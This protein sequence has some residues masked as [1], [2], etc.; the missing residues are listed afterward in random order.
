ME[1]LRALR[2]DR[3]G[4]TIVEFALVLPLFA[5]LLF[6]VIEAGRVL[7]L[8]NALHYAVEQAAR[9]V[10]IN[11]ALCGDVNSTI[12]YA[13]RISGADLSLATFTVDRTKTGECVGGY[14]VKGD[15]TTGMTIPFLQLTPHLT[16]KSCFPTILP[17]RP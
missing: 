9:C 3:R 6:G 10:S 11:T 17:A 15:E 1:Y 14:L 13:T 8:Q 4:A 12:A 16:G 2:Q 5:M 7:W